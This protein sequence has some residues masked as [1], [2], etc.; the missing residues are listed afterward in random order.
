MVS[1]VSA[2]ADRVIVRRLGATL[3][4]GVGIA[5]FSIVGGIVVSRSLGPV[6]R[7]ELALL[8]LWPQL[9]STLG[10]IGVDLG[11]TYYSADVRWRRNVP[12]T[13]LV[14]ALAQASLIV[15]AYLLLVPVLFRTAHMGTLPLWLAVLIPIDLCALYL[16]H[17]LNGR[18]DYR[19]FNVVRFSMSP[20]YTLG[21]V[22]LALGGRLTVMSAAVT[23]VVSNAVITLFAAVLTTRRYGV[24][25]WDSVLARNIVGF[26]LRGHLGRLAPQAVGADVVIV[27]LVLSPREL[28]LFTAAIAFLGVGRILVGSI[29]LVVFPEMRAAMLE[30]ASVR[31]IREM[32][33]LT[34]VVM[35]LLAVG[36]AV[37]GG[38]IAALVFGG[39]FRSAGVI[40]AILAVGETARGAYVLMLEGVRG[41][42]RPGLTSVIETCNWVVFAGCVGGAALLG[43]LMA[44][45]SGVAFASSFSLVLLGVLAGRTGALSFLSAGSPRAAAVGVGL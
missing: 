44:I 2:A 7:G 19:A 38:P 45:A 27:A 40:A 4:G 13:V 16:V 32:I 3:G 20:T 42:G 5:A 1:N 33:G 36:L 35:A 15:P 37:V 26:G 17:A 10:N 43:G 23:F 39:R 21:V 22:A 25:R 41:A 34:V 24:G 12:T 11:S 9:L 18:H 8:L 14:L 29:G 30:G 28:G 6:G 31:R